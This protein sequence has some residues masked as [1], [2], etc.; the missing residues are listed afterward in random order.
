MSLLSFLGNAA[1]S[2]GS[3]LTGGLSDKIIGA[4]EKFFPPSMS[5]QEKLEFKIK[6]QQ[7]THR[8]E[9]EMLQLLN[10][11][12]KEFNKRTIDLEGT[13]NDL[14]SIP[15]VGA[16]IIFLRGA[17][18]PLFSYFV[19]FLDYKV[20]SHQWILTDQQ[21]SLFWAINILVLGFFFGERAIKNITPIIGQYFGN[22]TNTKN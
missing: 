14:K 16:V 13:A 11:S 17:F 7:E 8:Q 21:D 15:F 10:E 6:L 19:F 3:F 12:E 9:L 2:I 5:E 18:R 1:E 4:V 22:K 20:F